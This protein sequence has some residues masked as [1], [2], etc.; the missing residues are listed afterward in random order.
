[1]KR[2]KALR[3]ASLLVEWAHWQGGGLSAQRYP[4]A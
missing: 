4:A 2:V 3:R 1:M